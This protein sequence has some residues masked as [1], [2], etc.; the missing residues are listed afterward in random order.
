MYCPCYLTHARQSQETK[1]CLETT[2]AVEPQHALWTKSREQ[3]ILAKFTFLLLTQARQSHE[4]KRCRKKTS[5]PE[6]QDT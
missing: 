2:F 5:A 3:Q 6:P 1:N 4:T